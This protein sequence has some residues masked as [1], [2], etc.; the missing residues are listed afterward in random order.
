MVYRKLK[1]GAHLG[2][3]NEGV[4]KLLSDFRYT[5]VEFKVIL[6]FKYGVEGLN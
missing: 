3:P 4:L 5:H 1:I 6:L 2:D